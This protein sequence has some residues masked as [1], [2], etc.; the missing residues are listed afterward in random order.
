MHDNMHE[1][2]LSVLDISMD[3]VMLSFEME[4]RHLACKFVHGIPER[5]IYRITLL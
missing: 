5:P 4:N 1:K 2:D 3:W